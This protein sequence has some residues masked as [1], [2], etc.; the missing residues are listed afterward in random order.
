MY[1]TI[2]KFFQF[3]FLA[4]PSAFTETALHKKMDSLKIVGMYLITIVSYSIVIENTLVQAH[5][6][7]HVQK[8]HCGQIF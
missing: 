1:L 7:L 2:K 8:Q 3:S 5:S 4:H 6:S